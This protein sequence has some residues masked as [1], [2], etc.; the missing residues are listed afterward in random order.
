MT[1]SVFPTKIKAEVML[2]KLNKVRQAVKSENY[3]KG[4]VEENKATHGRASSKAA[5]CR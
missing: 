4:A 5:L 3:L 1:R 2:E